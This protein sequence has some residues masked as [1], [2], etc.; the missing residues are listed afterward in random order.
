MALF[1]D[2]KEDGNIVNHT[3]EPD[4][5]SK[6]GFDEIVEERRI[7]R[8]Q[9]AENERLW[10]SNI[11]SPE[12]IKEWENKGKM[13]AIEV[14]QKKNKNELIPYMGTWQEGTET[15]GIK[16]I[17]DKLKK[18]Q[19][20]SP[21]ERQKYEDFILDMAE[22][23]TRGYTFGGGATNIGLET[24]PFMAEF[25]IGLLTTGG[26][27]SIGA[28]TS[29]IGAETVKKT[30]KQK[31]AEGVK[32]TAFNATLNPKTYAFTATRLP[33]QVR[34]RM[35]DIMLSDSIAITPEGQAILKEG[36]TSPAIAFM[37]ALAMTN[38]EVASEISGAML[39]RHVMQGA[40]QLSKAIASPVLKHLPDG[41]AE[42]FVKLAEE[43]TK[44]PFAKA[45][46]ELGFNGVLEEIGE[47]RVGDLLKFALNIDEEEGYSFEQLLDAV[48]P[49][50]EQLGQE[51]LSFG[52]TGVAMNVAHAGLKSLPKVGEKYTK[53]GFLIDAGIFRTHGY[54]SYLDSKV[55][56]ELTKKGKTEDEIENVLDFSTRDDKIQ[57]LKES[58][59]E[60]D[61][62]KQYD[63]KELEKELIRQNCRL[64]R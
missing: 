35:G 15:F 5:F 18:G 22:I 39:V 10:V 45:V 2:Y 1:Q 42:K 29:K 49:S 55:K 51:A 47:E 46:D 62:K 59:T 44:L 56:E 26:T 33:Q 50:A 53:D 20:V 64:T 31:I 16:N 24:L 8:E 14:W 11:V 32:K 54:D 60:F 43:A 57:F 34:A 25:G 13:T 4:T 7:N 30:V 41:F 19:V 48:F 58:K 63:E 40:G 3:V 28:T 61:S 38:V 12:R 36:E 9:Q 27:A 6:L 52:V 37:K 21:E 17:S 23:Q